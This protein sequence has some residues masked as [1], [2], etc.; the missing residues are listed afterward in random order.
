MWDIYNAITQ[1][2]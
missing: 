1:C 2:A